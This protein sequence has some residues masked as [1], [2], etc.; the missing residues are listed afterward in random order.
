MPRILGRNYG[1]HRARSY[2]QNLART[3]STALVFQLIREDGANICQ[4]H[5]AVNMQ[6]IAS[7]IA[8]KLQPEWT[9]L[10]QFRRFPAFSEPQSPAL[11]HGGNAFLTIVCAENTC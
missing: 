5:N 10:L 7:P 6:R 3:V 1:F 4:L 2:R 11:H 8:S 9:K